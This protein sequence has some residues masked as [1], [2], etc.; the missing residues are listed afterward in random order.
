MTAPSTPICGRCGEPIT[1]GARFCMKCGGDVSGEQGSAAT[2]MMP[3]PAERD[4][5]ELLLEQ[6]RHATL[7]EYEIHRELGHG[8]MATVYLAH[9]I[10][11]DRKVAIKVMAPALTLMGEGMSERFKREARTAANLSHPHI[12]PIYTVKSAQKTLYFVMKFVPGRSLESII[13]EIG[14]MPFAMVKAILQQVASALGYAHRHGIVHR[15]VKPA[16][17]MIDEEGWSVVT[18]FGIAKVAE[19]RQLTMTGIAVGTP[20]YMSPEQCAAK[21]IT[22][23][24]DQYSLGVVAYE[25]LTG[26][27]P[28]EG[29]SAMA[30]MFAH[31]HEQPK[32]VQEA[33]ADCPPELAAAVMKML[34]KAP[35]KRYASM[36]DAITALGAQPLAHDDP[37]RI[38]LL[39]IARRNSN[40]ELLAGITP[41]PT[42]PAPPAKTRPVPDAL[43]TPMPSTPPATRPSAKTTPIPTPVITGVTIVP[44]K[45]DLHVGDTMQLTATPRAQGG[46]AAP[47]H[48]ITWRTSDPLVASV[49]GS[50][51]VTALSTGSATISAVADG[52]TGAALVSVT[53]VPVMSVQVE[54]AE[55]TLA[56]G[57]EGELRAILRDQHGGPLSHREVRWSASRAELV[58]LSTT[59]RVTA[60]KA[61]TVE[62]EA[63]CEGVRG[64]ARITITPAPVAKVVVTPEA[65]SLTVGESLTLLVTLTDG[66]GRT[67]A[68]RTV[69][70]RSSA[71]RIATISPRGGVAGL[72]E[73]S[74]EITAE[75]EGQRATVTVK[76]VRAPVA[77]VTIHQPDPVLAGERMQLRAI[78]KDGRGQE[79]SGREVKWSS[80][81]PA[82]ATVTAAGMLTGM[83]PGQAKVTAE[84]EGKSWTVPVTVQPVPVASVTLEGAPK[85]LEVGGTASLR[86]VPK[87]QKGNALS[88]RETSWSSS[89]PKVVAV[90]PAGVVTAVA[91]GDAT[92][93]ATVEGKK[94]E[95]RLTVAAPPTR[96][97]ATTEEMQVATVIMPQAAAAPVPVAP[98]A[99]TPAPVPP[100]AMP[101]PAERAA[102]ILPPV[103]EPVGAAPSGGK[104][105]LIGIV[106]GVLVLAAVGFFL[107]RKGGSDIPP[108][109]E[110]PGVVVP[111]AVASI[112]VRGGDAP[113]QVG[114]TQQLSALVRDAGGAELSSRVTLW[115]SSDPSVAEVSDHGAVTGRKPGTATITVRSEGKTGTATINVEP[116]GADTPVPVATVALS[117]G[118]K[119]VEVGQEV[120]LEATAKDAKGTVLGDRSIVWSTSD[121][122]IAVVSSSG[123]VSAA[124]PGVATIE[125]SSEGKSAETR[126]TVKAPPAPPPSNN[127]PPVTPPVNLPAAPVAVASVTVAPASL[128]LT[129][130]NSG[131]LGATAL[132]EKRGALS[133]RPV[134]W[135]SS[136]ERVARVSGAGDVT[137][138]SEGS[139]TITATIEGKSAT[140]PVTVVEEQVAVG[141]VIMTATTRSLRVGESTTWIAATRDVKGKPLA[142]RAVSWTSSRPQVATVSGTGLIQAVGPGSSDIRA[143]SEGKSA[144]ATM[145]VAP[146]PVASNPTPPVSTP[147]TAPTPTPNAGTAALLPRRAVEAGGFSCGITQGSNAVCWGGGE[148]GL[149]AIEGTAGLGSISLGRAHACGL[150]SGGRAVCWG[151]NKVGQL[152]D[153]SSTGS[154]KAVAVQG[155]LGFSQISVGASHTCGLS[156]GRAFCWGRGKEGQL[157]DGGTSDRRR[158]VAVKGGLTF[159]SISAGATHTCAIT[160]TAKAYCWGDG[161]SGQLGFGAQET[162][163]E[164]VAVDGDLKFSR[165]AAGGQ[166]TCGISTSGKAYCWGANQAGQLGDGSK[167]DRAAPTA[168]S[169]STSFSEISAGLNHSCALTPG[170]EAFC[171]GE[172][173]AGQVG[174]G[175][176]NQR[177]KP[178]PVSGGASFSSISAGEAHTCGISNGQALCWG[179]ND[180]G[181]LG[182]GGTLGR[183]VPGAVTN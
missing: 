70:W 163:T 164:P 82:I 116:A 156:G 55:L 144:T 29:D 80:S 67:L 41:P 182:D 109:P 76:V 78:L 125:A 13:H 60:L 147:T 36:E 54:P 48:K 35:D 108:A 138:V 146:A 18:D 43:T 24:S 49:S 47:A 115:N 159:S 25:M 174:D 73:G 83:G 15:D 6:L 160:N 122:E 7:G 176:R 121:A 50:G 137:A 27:Q 51:F 20:S 19:N 77:S 17:I 33:R 133:G 95:L 103:V 143:E 100:P 106:A 75:S 148:T 92:I 178:T 68:D 132:D 153:G 173:R 21:D 129:A 12:I 56:E 23:K 150:L 37:V 57:A 131:T 102:P 28:F 2:A 161:F 104:G 145:T 90:T 65:P 38:A 16:N 79:L 4:A 22:G 111:A 141:S 87:D 166:H 155:D 175:S 98:A 157:G 154:L 110:L 45:N 44:A 179:K 91:A 105:K 39:E 69:T 81:S 151:D 71:E 130:G 136:D 34:E 177:E 180:R 3:A 99:V 118:G 126:I 42:S 134:Q 107:T 165:I 74:A 86:A 135:K 46:T 97:E 14:P 124:G 59:G 31:F 94:A 26:K 142:D 120:Q 168:V 123:L 58:A 10:A 8:G 32:P 169:S 40:R 167:S 183:A 53:P 181:Q 162:Q 140:A 1:P 117:G 93:S 112:A 9:D 96:P 158:P 5:Q 119:T 128:S 64:R 66:R 72:S 139:A 171:W 85:A 127:P 84:S 152:G 61:G 149:I 172:N 30:I 62:V 63:D 89:A 170:G 101:A 52:V 113:I 88:G 114:H 11:L